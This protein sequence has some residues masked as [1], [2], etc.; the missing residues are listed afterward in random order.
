MKAIPGTLRE[1]ALETCAQYG[2]SLADLT[3]QS[4]KREHAHPRH[5][6]M[7]RAR[8]VFHHTGGHRHSL[9]KIGRFLGGRD[10]T[11]VLHGVKRYARKEWGRAA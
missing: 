2:L 6:F 5:V 10:H 4:R 7:W 3:G 1:I 9:P 8:Q 11:S